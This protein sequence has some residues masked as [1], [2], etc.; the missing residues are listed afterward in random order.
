MFLLMRWTKL[1]IREG[2]IINRRAVGTSKEGLACEFLCDKGITI[3][4]KNFRCRMGE[5]D[6]IGRD[7]KYLV[8]FEVKYRYSGVSGYGSE[9][10][11]F[12]KR[13]I[14]CKVSDYYRMIKGIFEN[15]YIRFDVLTVTNDKIDWIQ[16]AFEYIK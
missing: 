15:E 14:I 1:R 11:D 6:I 12:R 13:R 4:E 16:N 10:V 5:I 7:D 9:A 8:F 3:L 2:E